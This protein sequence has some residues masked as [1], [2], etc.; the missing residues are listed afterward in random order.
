V[1]FFAF[2]EE[3]KIIFVVLKDKSNAKLDIGF[4]AFHDVKDISK[5]KLWLD[6]PKF[7]HMPA[8][9]RN[10][11]PECRSECVNVG[12]SACIVFNC[13][14]ARDCQICDF[15]EKL[16]GVINLSVNMRNVFDKATLRE[17]GGN[18]E[19]LS[20][21]FTVSSG[22]KGSV[23]VD[24]SVVLEELMGGKSEVVFYSGDSRHNLCPWT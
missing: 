19:H 24:E 15:L 22:D 10:F 11:S 23:N 13:K 2:L 18:L 14:L 17:D 12:E 3:L 4:S 8:S 6:H 20:S 21:S 16:F 9:V 7:S 5:S 1:S